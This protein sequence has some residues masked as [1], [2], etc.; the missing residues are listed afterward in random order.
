MKT[1]SSMPHQ[2]VHGWA[3]STETRAAGFRADFHYHDLDEWLEV[4]KGDIT[5]FTL[6]DQPYR[7]GVGQA[8]HIPQGEVHRVEVG[9][10][11]VEYQMWTPAPPAGNFSNQLTPPEVALLQKNL[12]FPVREDAG[13]AP[14]FDLIL[15]DQSMF[16][17]VDGV[18]LDKKRFKK[19][20][21]VRR[22]RSSAG[23]VRVLNRTTEGL[24]ISTVV[25]VAG[26]SFT[27]V[28][29]FVQEAGEPKCRVWVNYREPG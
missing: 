15:S 4:I 27:N 29:L 19:R 7:V 6:S 12:E 13:D 5:F 26:E 22:G 17:G 28:R 8:L 16:C 1:Y 20:G 21:F 25:T 3:S 14:F 9:S 24:L 10:V 23:S 11:R 2:V 18:V